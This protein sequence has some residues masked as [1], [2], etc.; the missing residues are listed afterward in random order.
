MNKKSNFTPQA[1]KSN[2][3]T[4]ESDSLGRF[5]GFD[6]MQF[7]NIESN[8]KQAESWI[9]NPNYEVKYY[10]VKLHNKINDVRVWC[11]FKGY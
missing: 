1:I 4:W 8:W 6:C 9:K 10:V 2:F 3:E 5:N 7:S 11:I